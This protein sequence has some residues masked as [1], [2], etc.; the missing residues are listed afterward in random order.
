[1]PIVLAEDVFQIEVNPPDIDRIALG[2]EPGSSAVNQRV[3]PELSCTVSCIS[4][5]FSG[6]P[7]AAEHDG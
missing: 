3:T 5:D 7:Q 2:Q 6:D 1:M 4:V